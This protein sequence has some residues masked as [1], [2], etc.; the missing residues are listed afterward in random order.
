MTKVIIE[1]FK[2]KEAAAAF[3]VWLSYQGRSLE[4]FWSDQRSLK[5]EEIGEPPLFM[6]TE[7]DKHGNFVTEIDN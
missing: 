5:H 7:E 3:A 1:G 6:R 4:N 2:T